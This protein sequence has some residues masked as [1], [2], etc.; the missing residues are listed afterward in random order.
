[1]KQWIESL[2]TRLEKNYPRDALSFIAASL[3]NATGNS[4]LWPLTTLYVHQVLG[5]T[6]AEAG[7]VL[8]FQA[9][10]GL[11]GQFAGGALYNR[12]GPKRLII[13]SMLLSAALIASVVF[14]R[15]YVVYVVLTSLYG[16]V[17]NL[18]VPS[19]NAY[20]GFRWKA[21][22]R[23]LYNAIYVG[24]NAGL[25]I[26]ASVGGLIA[27]FSFT[28]TYA[29]TAISTLVFGLYLMLIMRTGSSTEEEAV[30]ETTNGSA[31]GAGG[32]AG[33]A[34]LEQEATLGQKL[35]NTSMYLYLGIGSLLFFFALMIWN[36]GVAPF[37]T[38]G[39]HSLT[40]Y[41]LLWS[42]NGVVIFVGQPVTNAVKRMLAGSVSREIVA[43]SICY[44]IGFTFIAFLHDSYWYL[45]FGMIVC[46]IGEMLLLPVI[47]AFLSENAGKSAPFYMGVVGGFGSAGRMI[48]PTLF[49]YV[50]DH[51]GVT[52]VLWIGAGASLLSVA[53]F[54]VHAYL[55]RTV[56]KRAVV[57]PDC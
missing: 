28:L 41:S 15:E 20:I 6:Y 8:L 33:R 17:N 55:H 13:G 43:S 12:L 21:H 25:A 31:L 26:G 3:I 30:L 44:S 40:M 57:A 49:G 36:N 35:R 39:G 27:A 18:A 10:A 29:V 23:K 11:I 22:R 7:M 16:L 9:L 56:P 32:L 24:N 19:I 53:V 52:P 51:T 54:V 1:M 34:Q 50:Y 38:D 42:I 4:I 14:T 48:A 47:P 45:V 46:T 5:R 37:L 2:I